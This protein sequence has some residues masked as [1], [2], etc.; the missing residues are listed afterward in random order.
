[1]VRVIFVESEK[2]LKPWETP[3]AIKLAKTNKARCEAIRKLEATPIE[4]IPE[5]SD[6]YYYKKMLDFNAKR[7]DSL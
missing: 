5:E 7:R 1:M 4:S 3:K 6:D 2:N